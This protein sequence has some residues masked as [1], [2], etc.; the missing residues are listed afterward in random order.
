[1]RRRLNL[2]A[3]AVIAGGGGLLTTP[4]PVQATYFD[5]KLILTQSCC[6]AKNHLGTVIYRCCSETGCVSTRLRS[7]TERSL[8]RQ[9]VAARGAH[10]PLDGCIER[11][12]WRR[13]RRR[14]S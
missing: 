1:M 12:G 8:L 13:K 6:E 9:R 3:L 14:D 10:A 11:A 7:R 4:A 2:L 5:P